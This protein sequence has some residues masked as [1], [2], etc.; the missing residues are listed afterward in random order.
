METAKRTATLLVFTLLTLAPAGSETT[1]LPTAP[2]KT[3]VAATPA[4][5]SA[6]CLAKITASP[7][8][9]P[10]TI[11][12]IQYILESPSVAGKAAQ[13][14]LGIKLSE[15]PDR[16]FKI[17]VEQFTAPRGGYGGGYGGGGYGGGDMTPPTFSSSRTRS[18]T[19]STSRPQSTNTYYGS[20]APSAATTN[21]EPPRNRRYSS[22]SRYSGD[23]TGLPGTGAYGTKDE[24]LA[25]APFSYYSTSR[26]GS[27]RGR[28][29]SSTSGY[30]SYS[31][32]TAYST[33]KPNSSARWPAETE[34]TLFCKLTVHILPRR[35]GKT[36]AEPFMYAL[37]RNLTD[38]LNSAWSHNHEIIEQNL[39]FAKSQLEEARKQLE[40]AIARAQPKRPT[41]V[42]ALDPADAAVYNQLEQIVD[43]SALEPTTPLSEAFDIIKN[44]VD[45]PLKIVVLW[46]DLYDNAEIEP[47]TEINL[48]GLPAVP[49]QRGIDSILK[50]VAGGF[51]EKI[52]FVIQDGVITIATVLSLPTTLETR[53]YEVPGAL[54]S[55]QTAP[56]LVQVIMRTIEPE[57]WFQNSEMGNGEIAPYMGSKLVILQTPEI[58]RKIGE[59]LKTVQADV[60][61][62]IPPDV[63]PETLVQDSRDLQR[64]RRLLEM[65]V[66]RLQARRGAIE[67]AIART[68]TEVADKLSADSVTTELERI[69]A[70]NEKQL[71]ATEA[72]YKAGTAPLAEIELMKEKLARARIELAKRRE[73]LAKSAGGSQLAAFNAELTSISIDLT[74]K[75]AGLQLLN[76]HLTQARSQLAA[77][78]TFD[79]RTADIRLAKEAFEAS[80]KRIAHLQGL[81]AD[82]TL[83]N[84]TVIGGP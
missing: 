65:E 43:L 47:T 17:T 75:S 24:N 6:S 52:G 4:I 40:E 16:P 72:R 28:Y 44:S 57:S 48:D 34:Q 81:L 18:S 9:M 54:G 62:N 79:P 80:R 1:A 58:H 66:A 38:V 5:D 23:G 11:D 15:S 60:A 39:S 8:V 27:T 19:S 49:L 59:F 71:A 83:P 82:L 41:T 61:V 56:D 22:Y 73:E 29:G 20:S 36:V 42:A 7:S 33:T 67:Q 25:Y 68:T 10:L 2:A 64:Q 76:T 31:P 70:T 13:E 63:A 3:S 55:G 21:P 12:T 30:Y 53:V 14:V 45:P 50:A 32:P 69:L 51:G 35:P 46:R 74:E 77:A 84:L 78:N 37:I 26:P